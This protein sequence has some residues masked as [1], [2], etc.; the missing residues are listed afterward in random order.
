VANGAA[1]TRY[2][3]A[4]VNNAGGYPAGWVKSIA[5]DGFTSGK[6]LTKG[7]IVSFGTGANRHSYTVLSV[8]SASGTQQSV[9]LN[10]PL[11]AAI[12]DNDPV[13]PGPQGGYNL[14]A[15]RNAIT[16]VS[17]PLA[18]V[19][20][21]M[22]VVTSVVQLDGLGIRMT[23]GYDQVAQKYRVTVDL[24]YGVKTLDPRLGVVVF[25]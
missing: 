14:A 15:H 16:L 1:I 4:L 2:N 8:D 7:Q 5:M 23:A 11:A 6:F 20:A 18:E 12:A 3:R 19:P 13:F 9:T 21:G 17:R 22:G 24:L 10:K 25:A